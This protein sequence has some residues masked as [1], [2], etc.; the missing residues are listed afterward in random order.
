MNDDYQV[1]SVEVPPPLMEVIMAEK[2]GDPE[3]HSAAFSREV[4]LKTPSG[5]TF[6]FFIVKDGLLVTSPGGELSITGANEHSV[7]LNVRR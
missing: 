6:R 2:A 5:D 3:A 7:Y 1:K 4:L